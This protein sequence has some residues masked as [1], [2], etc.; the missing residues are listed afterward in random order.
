MSIVYV[1]VLLIVIAALI[2][3]KSGSSFA[4]I[5]GMCYRGVSASKI[6]IVM[7][8]IVGMLTASWRMSGTIAFFVYYG[9]KVIMPATFII[10]GYLL[11]TLLSYAV[12]SSFAVTASVGVI[13][14]ALARAGGVD[15]LVMGGAILSGV[16]FGD[17]GAPTSSAAMLVASVT[18]T[19]HM[20]NVRTMAK[21]CVLPLLISIV[22]Y[23]YLSVS[24]PIQSVDESFLVKLGEQ[25][26]IS[27]WCLI[28]AALMLILPLVK[29]DV[30][31]AMLSSVAAALLI[32]VSVQKTG[33]LELVSV[34]LF[35]YESTTEFGVIFNGGGIRS[36]IDV[37]LVVVLSGALAG[38]FNDTGMLNGLTE[39]IGR[40]MDKLGHFGTT[41]LVT[42]V[43]S[44][45]ACNQS[46]PTVMA[47]PLLIDQY[48]KKGGSREELASDMQNSYIIIV[49][50]I[51]WAIACSVPLAFM[52]VDYGACKYA[53]YMFLI[54]LLYPIQKRFIK[55]R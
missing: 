46:F 10:I 48:E 47:G 16:Y 41:C 9:I 4:E 44:A 36:M 25:F 54:P 26:N 8:F 29:V 22:L 39:R 21:F 18:G 51:P 13:F 35:G 52:G 42:T 34:L 27:W 7:M 50:L 23:G 30:T 11:A 5:G 28:P 6:V 45:I 53:F 43:L 14:M 31:R 17:R 38:I 15:P 40:L 37:I 2:A 24:N 12:G 33:L 1:L 32:A 55:I 20:K 19:D 49:G 3:R